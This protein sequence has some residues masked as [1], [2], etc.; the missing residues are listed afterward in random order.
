M[1]AQSVILPGYYPLQTG[2]GVARTF[3]RLL[4]SVDRVVPINALG[5][6]TWY[7][8]LSMGDVANSIQTV[9]DKQVAAFLGKFIHSALTRRESAAFSYFP[10]TDSF[11]AIMLVGE[12]PVRDLLIQFAS[13]VLATLKDTGQAPET[14]T[15]DDL[16]ILSAEIVDAMA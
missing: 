5:G 9:P 1:I 2:T 4:D 14:F 15:R 13:S 7:V 16:A 12:R 3:N 10:G 8:M 6:T 11:V